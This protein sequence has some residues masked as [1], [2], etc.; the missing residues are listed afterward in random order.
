M[1][2]LERVLKDATDGLGSS[3]RE[4]AQAAKELLA[5]QVRQ[6]W[7]KRQDPNEN[8]WAGL[9]Q[10]SFAGVL[11]ASHRHLLGQ[12]KSGAA[13]FYGKDNLTPNQDMSFLGLK[14]IK[15]VREAP[16]TDDGFATRGRLPKYWSWQ[17][18]GTNN[19]TGWGGPIPAREF[20][21]FGEDTLELIG[22]LLAEHGMRAI[23]NVGK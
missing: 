6:S 16:V 21:A 20:W 13:A 3:V 19:N 18:Q 5:K 4:V 22:E 7:E 10:P 23:V 17:D 11:K 15:D 9:K 1:K 8:A 2:S 12:K 14:A